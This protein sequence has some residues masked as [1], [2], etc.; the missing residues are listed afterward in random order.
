MSHPASSS[1]PQTPLAMPAAYI[2]DESP[3]PPLTP[4]ADDLS[5]N[6]NSGTG[7][8]Y[9]SVAATNTRVGFTTP[10]ETSP[11]RR[12]TSFSF[13]RASNASSNAGV[14]IHDNPEE[15]RSSPA[16]EHPWITVGRGGRPLRTPT[17][18]ISPAQEADIRRAE[19]LLT[20]DQRDAILR[21]RASVH[22]TDDDSMDT[23]STPRDKGKSVDP[24]ERGEPILRMGGLDPV[25]NVFDA[26]TEE[27]V[28][29]QRA[30]L[31][32]WQ[33]KPN[34][35]SSPK[36]DK[37]STSHNVVL[38]AHPNDMTLTELLKNLKLI[39]DRF[40]RLESQVQNKP[41]RPS[42]IKHTAFTPEV[43]SEDE[44][45]YIKRKVHGDFSRNNSGT[46]SRTPS[47]NRRERRH[48]SRPN[49]VVPP[50][51]N[52]GRVFS[53]V[54]RNRDYDSEGDP[55][56]DGSD[57]EDGGGGLWSSRHKS[58]KPSSKLKAV[59][60][61]VFT[62]EPKI[63]LFNRWMREG[64]HYLDDA[65]VERRKEIRA[66]ARYTEGKAQAYYQ[67]VIADDKS[68][69]MLEEY[70]KAIYDVCFPSN[71]REK[72]R[73]KLERFYQGELLV[74][75]Y[76]AQMYDMINTIGGLDARQRVVH[77][78]R[79]LN[80][81]LAIACRRMGLNPED[82]SWDEVVA[83]AE[84]EE[85]VLSSIRK[86]KV[87][88][89]KHGK[90]MSTPSK[91]SSLHNS[92]GTSRPGSNSAQ[93]SHNFRNDN[94][95]NSSGNIGRSGQASGSEIK[96]TASGGSSGNRH[97]RMPAGRG[98]ISAQER[99]KLQSEGKCF[100]CKQTGHIA[101]NCPKAN[102]L[103][104]KGGKPPGIRVDNIDFSEHMVDEYLP[105]EENP[106]CIELAML[107]SHEDSSHVEFTESS[108]LDTSGL[109]GGDCVDSNEDSEDITEIGT[110]WLK[111]LK[112]HYGGNQLGDA[113]ANTYTWMLELSRDLGLPGDD[114]REY[115]W[116]DLRFSIEKCSP[117]HYQV[118]DRMH[119][120]RVQVP[121]D[122]L[123]SNSFKL[124][125]WYT[126]VLVDRVAPDWAGV[127]DKEFYSATIEPIEFNAR[128]HLKHKL[129][130]DEH[131]VD[132][133]F[134]IHG[135]GPARER[136]HISEDE[137]ETHAV[138]SGRLLR[139]EHLNLASWYAKHAV[140]WAVN[141]DDGPFLREP[142][143]D[144]A[145]LYRDG[146]D[147]ALERL[148]RMLVNNG[149]YPLEPYLK[150]PSYFYVYDDTELL[151]ELGLFGIQVD[152]DK[153]PALQRNAAI[154]KDRERIVPSPVVVT[155]EI[156]GKPAKALLDSGSLGD[157]MSS[158]LAD[159]LGR[160]NRIALAK[161]IPLQLAVQGSRTKINWSCKASISYQAINE[162]RIFDVINI[163][164]YDLILGTP[165]MYQHRVLLGLNPARVVVGSEACL[166]LD[167]PGVSRLASMAVNFDAA[168][169]ERARRVA[170]VCK[171][172]L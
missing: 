98:D 16:E 61:T 127:S 9:S 66:L 140:P 31:E 8:S 131:L 133:S 33:S 64:L 75:E 73:R 62:G 2:P 42:E 95:Q 84:N 23:E 139:N 76:A 143:Y 48:V 117:S 125:L 126:Q 112:R 83:E 44:R 114:H 123:W 63:D 13:P 85:I 28:A 71:F 10:R 160:K 135:Y 108:N 172:S 146:M 170:Q 134:T 158:M 30:A 65:R 82:A 79:G 89:D 69:W 78:F 152:C 132:S 41:Q 106:T 36:A 91:A 171:T 96:N 130:W 105:D 4:S 57:P 22:V 80:P 3:L 120:M 20:Q 138:I 137:L 77:L 87:R 49:K 168:N 25:V 150:D 147:L 148:A 165:F 118:T 103:P 40:D 149:F 45:R 29:E 142:E 15:S 113:Y 109:L 50:S 164:N 6:Q 14:V 141:P 169:V 21:R 7:A 56:S 60:P 24:R 26:P 121:A 97:N 162:E 34:L 101:R 38:S 166:P 51:S 88:V 159:Q 155:V 119:D 37:A 167:G 136:W 32:F 124:G 110:R 153:L 43:L 129:T 111:F 107:G 100:L 94:C 35:S 92:N 5:L 144:I 128:M 54:A 81:E 93:R 17:P 151:D 1:E 90:D 163:S 104:G 52:V 161:P 47:W 74:K 99:Q 55:S 154:V 102:T 11:L 72:Q 116:T 122:V 156:N 12:D 53:R 27:D 70:F 68:N 46:D 86:D 157:F 19:E 18:E 39:Q 145:D 58:K 59:A 67:N 115:P